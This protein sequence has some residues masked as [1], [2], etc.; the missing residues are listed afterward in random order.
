MNKKTFTLRVDLESDKGIQFGVPKLLNLLKKYNLKA[1]FY[2][3]MGGESN[4]FEL[5]S[6]RIKIKSAGERNIKIFSLFEKLRMVLFP[7]GRQAP[8]SLMVSGRLPA[9]DISRRPLPM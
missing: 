8:N 1:S 4:I 7:K 3:P 9:A 6:N 5:L 2:I